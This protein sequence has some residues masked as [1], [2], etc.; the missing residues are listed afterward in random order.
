MSAPFLSH[1][2][3]FLLVR[4]DS[5]LSE[6]LM[7]DLAADDRSVA[8]WRLLATLADRDE[9][10]IGELAELTLLPQPT[11]SRWVDR[12]EQRGLLR[13]SDGQ[14]DRRRTHVEITAAGAAQAESM[15]SM[16]GG[17]LSEATSSLD[18]GDLLQ[19]EQ[20]LHRLITQLER[21]RREPPAAIG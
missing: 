5:L 10:T 20:L 18:R 9:A 11:V 2:L 13:R 12:L 17:R 14:H 16:A 3:P 21:R 19:L 4:A 15:E 6:G 7:S 1:Y 8:E